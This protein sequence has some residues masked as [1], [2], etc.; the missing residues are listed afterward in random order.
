MFEPVM[1]EDSG[2]G[3]ERHRI[4]RMVVLFPSGYCSIFKVIFEP[5]GR[6]T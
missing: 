5:V 1:Y 2:T 3:D 6:F 4:S